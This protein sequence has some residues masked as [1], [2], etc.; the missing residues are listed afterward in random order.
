MLILAGASE[1]YM[2]HA[3]NGHLN[4]LRV[5]WHG[6]SLCHPEQRGTGMICGC[7][8]CNLTASGRTEFTSDTVMC[9]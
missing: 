5:G 6:G 7:V 9:L 4:V 1:Y 3:R 2:L 8:H